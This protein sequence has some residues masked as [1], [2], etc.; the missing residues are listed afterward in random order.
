MSAAP[1]YAEALDV[2]RVWRVVRRGGELRLRSVVQGTL[3]VPGKELVAECLRR[4]FSLLPWRR[5][6]C[7]HEA[8]LDDC[9]CGIYGASLEQ[10]AGYFDDGLGGRGVHRVIGR[11]RLW[12]SVVE[13][14]RGLRASRAYPARIYVPTCRADGNRVEA[15]EEVALALTDYG[16]P[17]EILDCDS[18]QQLFGELASKACV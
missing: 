9:D 16:V 5:R 7:R 8:P 2:W 12:G 6:A 14:E 17:I 1:D 15:T 18:A 10:V 3:W 13:C 11:V 4:Q